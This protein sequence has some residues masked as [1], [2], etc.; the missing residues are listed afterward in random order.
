VPSKAANPSRNL[1]LH[2]LHAILRVTRSA[3]LQAIIRELLAGLPKT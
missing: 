3:R 1:D 2:L